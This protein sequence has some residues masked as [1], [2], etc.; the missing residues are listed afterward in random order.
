MPPTNVSRHVSSANNNTRAH[1]NLRSQ[2]SGPACMQGGSV[3]GGGHGAGKMALGTGPRGGTLPELWQQ[4]ECQRVGSSCELREGGWP[5]V[6][7]ASG[8]HQVVE[9]QSRT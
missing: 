9:M 6:W 4:R 3:L 1:H 8:R 7:Q 5:G 2:I